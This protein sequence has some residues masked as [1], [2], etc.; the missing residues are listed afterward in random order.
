MPA[1]SAAFLSDLARHDWPGNVRE[2]MNVLERFLVQHH[3]GLLDVSSPNNLIGNPTSIPIPVS[4]QARKR[5]RSD[6]AEEKR[7]SGGRTCCS[8]RK[9]LQAGSQARHCAQHIA[10]PDFSSQYF[11]PNPAGLIRAISDPL[12]AKPLSMVFRQSRSFSGLSMRW[13]AAGAEGDRPG[14]VDRVSCLPSRG[15][16]HAHSRY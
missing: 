4:P 11:A 15:F 7:F 10:L 12:F 5:L 9:Y 14:E 8:G 2:L 3:A 16:D 13:P 1:V 6:R